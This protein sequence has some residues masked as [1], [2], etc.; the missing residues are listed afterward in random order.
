MLHK[1]LLDVVLFS[2][3]NEL[4]AQY[5]A[6]T[7]RSTFLEVNTSDTLAWEKL[8]ETS[9]SREGRK[10]EKGGELE[11]TRLPDRSV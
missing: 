3:K 5:I 2:D 11:I 6:R 7:I 9:N 4:K 1:C 10:V 8:L